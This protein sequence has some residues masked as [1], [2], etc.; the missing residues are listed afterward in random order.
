MKK[1]LQ[2]LLAVSALGLV[3]SPAFAGF[4]TFGS[5]VVLDINGTITLYEISLAGDSRL[6][7][8]G[9]S[10]VINST[11]QPAFA[12]GSKNLGTFDTV[13]GTPTF[14]LAGGDLLTY[15]N[16]GD[17]VDAAYVSFQID[18]GAITN[19]SLAF[20]E[21]NVAT[22]SGDQR[23]YSQTGG[24]IGHEVNLLTGLA[25]GSH[26]LTFWFSAH[27]D[28]AGSSAYDSN[29]GANYSATFSVV[30]EPSSVALIALGGLFLARRRRA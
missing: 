13:Y 11:S 25:D 19:M 5:G 4:G 23:W 22:T 29:G 18:G 7:P 9:S 12:N 15:K 20:N 30:P 3:T 27:S 8:L 16:S 6:A 24:D 2:T 1:L 26:T 17:N 14:N 10:P 28:T 21:D